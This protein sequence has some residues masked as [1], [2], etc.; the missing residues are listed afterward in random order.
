MLFR[1]F[2]IASADLSAMPPVPLGRTTPA[3]FKRCEVHLTKHNQPKI[4]PQRHGSQ[5]GTNQD[6]GPCQSFFFF[7]H[8]FFIFASFVIRC[9]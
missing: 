2:P 3:R 6:V 1:I 8:F 4:R 5:A 9:A 7:F